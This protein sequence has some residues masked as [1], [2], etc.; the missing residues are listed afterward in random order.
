PDSIQAPE[1]IIL[2]VELLVEYEAKNQ[3][4]SD[5]CRSIIKFLSKKL[6][7]ADIVFEKDT[8]DFLLFSLRRYQWWLRY[9]ICSWFSYTLSTPTQQLPT[10]L[11]KS[12]PLDQQE[13]CEQIS[14]DFSFSPAECFFRSFFE[15]ALFDIEL[16]TDFLSRGI[17][18]HPRD[19][20]IVEK[21]ALALV[22]SYEQTCS[23]QSVASL[24]PLLQELMKVLDPSQEVRFIEFL[25]ESTF[26][27]LR[28]IQHLLLLSTA[29]KIAYYKSS[30]KALNNSTRFKDSVTD[31]AH[32]ANA[33]LQGFCELAKAH[34]E[35]EVVNLRRSKLPFPPEIKED[36][37]P[38][39][40]IT[41]RR[42][43]RVYAQLSALFNISCSIT[44]LVVQPPVALQV[45]IN[46]LAELLFEVQKMRVG[47]FL[48]DLPSDHFKSN[49]VY[50]FAHPPHPNKEAGSPK[51]LNATNQVRGSSTHAATVVRNKDGTYSVENELFDPN[52]TLRTKGKNGKKKRAVKRR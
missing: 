33:L 3:Q 25:C 21:I 6:E 44:R 36:Y 34:A 12:L 46:C 11:Y 40:Q 45:L 37:L 32:V 51:Q 27:G 22:E 23:T 5:I 35:K 39:A 24:A 16:A 42:D 43:E 26:H 49:T 9:A 19:E 7:G 2:V 4:A 20:N 8:V 38:P 31:T 48:D 41:I 47:T 10:G 18:I 13:R 14:V 52:S 28:L 17:S 15:L 1:L 29:V 30:D 50:A